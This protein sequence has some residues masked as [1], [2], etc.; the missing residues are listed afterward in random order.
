VSEPLSHLPKSLNFIY[1]FKFYSNFTNKNVSWLHF[2]WATQYTVTQCQLQHLHHE[3]SD[4]MS[5]WT[6]KRSEETQTLHAD[7]SK[8]EPKFF[9]PPQTPFPGRGT[10]E[11]LISWRWS[12]PS[13]TKPVCWGSMHTISS[14]RGNRPT[15]T[16][17][18]DRLQYTAQ[19]HTVRSANCNIHIMKT[20]V[21]VR[22]NALEVMCLDTFFCDFSDQ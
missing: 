9:A 1:P 15:H 21:L 3:N 2:S 12:L 18:Q 19:K 14:Y 5:T 4:N 6:K 10:A 20:L 7:C 13:P 11:N 17:T 22:C 16:P 8:V